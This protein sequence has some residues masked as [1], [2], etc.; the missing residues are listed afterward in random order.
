M[1]CSAL[2]RTTII[3][4]SIYL[5]YIY[6]IFIHLYIWNFVTSTYFLFRHYNI[7]KDIHYNKLL[8]FFFHNIIIPFLVIL[9][10][11]RLSFGKLYVFLILIHAWYVAVTTPRKQ[12][13]YWEMSRDFHLSWKVKRFLMFFRNLK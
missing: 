2:C 1:L 10:Q 6:N 13:G 3:Y 8:V 5:L 7:I 4:F 12:R 9:Y 11:P